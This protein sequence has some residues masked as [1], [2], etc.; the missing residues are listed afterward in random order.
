MM[1]V[2]LTLK[3]ALEEASTYISYNVRFFSQFVCF[4]ADVDNDVS[5][6]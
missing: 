6:A 1:A 2:T 3:L 4:M 5:E